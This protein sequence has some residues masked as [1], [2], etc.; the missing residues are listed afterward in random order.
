MRGTNNSRRHYLFCLPSLRHKK[1]NFLN[2]LSCV[3][4]VICLSKTPSLVFGFP[5]VS[6]LYFFSIS[7]VQ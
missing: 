2:P 3:E 5:D 4:R 6:E 1:R 7:Y